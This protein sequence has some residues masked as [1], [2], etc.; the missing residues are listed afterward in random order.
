[1]KRYLMLALLLPTLA[2][3]TSLNWEN[4]PLNYKNMD[5]NYDNSS[6]KWDNNPLNYRNNDLN[7]NQRNGVYNNAGDQ[8]G[9]RTR[10]ATG[11]TNYFDDDGYRLGYS[12][13]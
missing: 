1:M 11:V 2:N 10:N 4:S 5:I 9:Y 13:E 12:D 8:I 7:Y 3:A 6:M